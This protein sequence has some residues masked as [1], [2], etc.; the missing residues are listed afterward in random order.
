MCVC[1]C[2]PYLFIIN[3]KQYHT[4]S[5][6]YLTLIIMFLEHN[7]ISEVSCY[8]EDWSNDTKNSA[9]HHRNKCHFKLYS[10][11]KQIFKNRNDG[12]QTIIQFHL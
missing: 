7:H 11:R 6:L 8:T 2:T 3:E 4:T 9:L 12:S 10:N 1:V 5:Q